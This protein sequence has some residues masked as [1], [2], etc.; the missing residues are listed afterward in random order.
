MQQKN[1]EKNYGSRLRVVK[2]ETNPSV[3]S[4]PVKIKKLVEPK[5]NMPVERHRYIKPKEHDP[6]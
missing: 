1:I 4:R 3:E 2:S 6:L 5:L